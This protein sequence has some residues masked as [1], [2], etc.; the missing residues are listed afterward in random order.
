MPIYEYYCSACDGRFSHLARRMDEPAPR[1][2]GCD[3]ID[4]EKMVSLFAAGRSELDRQAAFE[5]G[6]REVD[7]TD[8]QEMARFLQRAGS[9]VDQAAPV[10][11]DLFREVVDRRA[12]GASDGD[13]QDVSDA[14]SFEAPGGVQA[15]LGNH[16]HCSHCQGHEHG[17][18]SSGGREA[19]A[20][21]QARDLGWSKRG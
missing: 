19:R 6:A 14:M 4:V 15:D 11:R 2:P 5:A 1:C 10:D 16:D 8:P 12:R 3:S 9:L 20:R 21:S 7:Q 13:L 18:T 17:G